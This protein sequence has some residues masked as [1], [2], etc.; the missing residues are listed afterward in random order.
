MA[1][2]YWTKTRLY[3]ESQRTQPQKIWMVG[4]PVLFF[5]QHAG[6]SLH[7]ENEIA[8]KGL[9]GPPCRGSSP[10]RGQGLDLA[11]SAPAGAAQSSLHWLAAPPRAQGPIRTGGAPKGA[12]RAQESS[13]ARRPPCRDSDSEVPVGLGSGARPQGP[14][15]L[16]VMWGSRDGGKGSRAE[17]GVGSGSAN[18]GEESRP[19]LGSSPRTEQR[20]H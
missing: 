5:N 4:F 11:T 7:R 14:P 18:R 19:R 9:D 13:A 10:V 1:H 20:R 16:D 15:S 8:H 12:S 3:W 6:T 2:F 17:S